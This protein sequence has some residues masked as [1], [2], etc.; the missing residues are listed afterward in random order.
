MRC[1]AILPFLCLL[2]AFV[3]S[4]LMLF[5]GSKP[6]FLENYD[7]LTVSC[8]ALTSMATSIANDGRSSTPP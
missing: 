6:G 1:L 4:M 3:L 5:A 8:S 7:L 2:V